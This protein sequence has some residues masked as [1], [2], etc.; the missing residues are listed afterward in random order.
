MEWLRI[1][2]DI[3]GKYGT[4]PMDLYIATRGIRR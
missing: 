4:I 2:I 3:F 1:V